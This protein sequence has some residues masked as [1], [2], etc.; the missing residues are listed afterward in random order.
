LDFLDVKLTPLRKLFLI[1]YLTPGQPYFQKAYEAAIKA[2]YSHTTARTDIYEILRLPDIQKIIKVNESIAYQKLHAAAMRAMALK[3]LRAF[4]DPIDYFEEKEVTKE[5]KKGDVYKT[6]EMRLKDMKDMTPEQR[7]CIDGVEIKGFA[8]IPTY[9]MADRDK[10]ADDLIKLDKE[11]SKSSGNEDDETETMEI[12]MERLTVK[13][14]VRKTK[15]AISDIAGLK[16]IP[17]VNGA[18]EL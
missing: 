9:L 13:S 15:D 17:Q 5:S 12:I 14:T 8:S 6:R 7:L 2:G 18:I 3:E 11:A 1:Y 10:N 4:Y 16:K